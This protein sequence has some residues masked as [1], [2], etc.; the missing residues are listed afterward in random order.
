M[1]SRKKKIAIIT[2]RYGR[3]AAGQVPYA[4]AALARRLAAFYS[5]TVLTSTAKD[6]DSF[7]NYYPEGESVEDGV[8]LLRFK[9]TS[10]RDEQSF[11]RL[12]ALRVNLGFAG[13][14]LDKNL[15]GKRDL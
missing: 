12:E 7:A 14:M 1:D 13:K 8:K 15:Y 4:A 3:E 9:T 6:Y 5:V 2:P 10:D 11:E